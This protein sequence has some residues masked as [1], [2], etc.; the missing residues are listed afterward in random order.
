[1]KTSA[2]LLQAALLALTGL[3]A[4]FS[5]CQTGKSNVAFTPVIPK[6]WDDAAMASLELPL[7]N[8]S[9]S[10]KHIS[11]K[12]Y[13][14]LPVRPIYKTYPSYHPDQ[15]PA[16]YRERLRQ[17][18]PQILWDDRGTRPPLRTKADW[19]KAGELVFQSPILFLPLAPALEAERDLYRQTGARVTRD[20][21]NPLEH[22]IVRERGKIEIGVG[23]VPIVTL[24]S[25][26]T[27]A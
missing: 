2:L 19:I 16:G 14:A 20:G 13:Y 3:A 27:E 12:E 17:A 4:F 23:S 5:G 21:I 6:T 8:P 9:A 15:Q 10:P 18:R 22:L 24:A 26:R 7:A 25:C 11:E 1:M